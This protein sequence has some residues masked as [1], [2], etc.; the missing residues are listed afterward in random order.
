VGGCATQHESLE[1]CLKVVERGLRPV[2]EDRS[3][4]F[5]G[6]VREDTARCRGGERAVEARKLPWIDWQNYWATGDAGSGSGP[7]THHLSPHG[8][9]THVSE[10]G[11]G[12]DVSLL[13]LEYQRIELIKFN[14]FDTSG[15][16]E[17]YV[18]GRDG[19]GGPAL[20]VWPQ[21]RLPKGHPQYDAVGGDQ[22]QVC[23]GDLIR[24]RTLTGI[25]NDLKN[26]LM[27]SSHQPFPRYV[28][29]EVTF[30]ELS[31]EQLTRNRHG[32]RL[33]LLKPDPQVI[34]RRLFTRPQ[35][36]TEQR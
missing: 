15:T 29:F 9:A 22:T 12:I 6:K 23:G 35:Y 21:M 11:R 19:V 13:D 27:G 18:R 36:K 8:R 32:D 25:C 4:R 2:A 10:N 5:L 28:Q 7:E 1:S 34:S 26:P 33:D 20:K 24:A 31:Q 16:Y 3:Q 17:V 30:P 14:L